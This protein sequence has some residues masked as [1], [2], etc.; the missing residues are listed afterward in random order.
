VD[1]RIRAST[2]RELGL[3]SLSADRFT[4]WPDEDDTGHSFDLESSGE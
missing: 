3:F 1:A 2:R 4:V